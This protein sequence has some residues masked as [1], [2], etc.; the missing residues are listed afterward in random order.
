MK[1]TILLIVTFLML[2]LLSFASAESP[3]R[4]LKNGSS[5][6]DVKALKKRLYELGYFTS[7]KFTE[8]FTADTEKRIRQFES[9]CGFAETGIATQ[10]L[11]TLI[12]SENAYSRKLSAALNG[13]AVTLP[14]YTGN[15]Y[16]DF[17]D[18][19]SGDDVLATKKQLIIWRYFN[20]TAT[21]GTYNKTLITAAKSF[22]AYLGHEQTGYLT[23][24]EQELLFTLPTP[25]PTPSPTP[26]PTPTPKVTATP[27]GPQKQVELPELNEEHFLADE[28]AAPFSYS[29]RDD[30]QWYYISHD[31]SIAIRRYSTKSP[32]MT[33]FEAEIYCTP[34][35][36]P[37]AMLG[38]GRKADGYN[39]IGPFDI[40]NQYNALFAFSDDYFGIRHY[41][42]LPEGIII[43]G[44][45]VISTVTRPKGNKNFPPLDV[46]ALFND[47]TMRVYD[48]DE[49]TAEEYLQ[50]GVTDTFAFGP[51]LIE[52]SI[53]NES[54]FISNVLNNDKNPRMALGMV[55]PCHYWAVLVQGRISTSNGCT[56]RWLANHMLGMGCTQALNL[57]GGGS[58]FMWFMGDMINRAANVNPDKCRDLSSMFGYTYPTD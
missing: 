4:T 53:V 19:C 31:I 33:W 15:S 47:G 44:G 9:D 38:K 29:N 32:L 39:L 57:D 40:V 6:D 1:K 3:Y 46:L 10:E 11:Q 37:S 49:H 26:K 48:S 22:Q 56:F 7:N 30:G 52:D 16:R 45:E 54:L 41:N 8:D 28:S 42:K 18:G 51:I 5:G 20:S 35:S 23:A 13:E 14:E 25:S 55:E 2:L 27:K 43:R 24:E 50:M 58:T 36:L 21:T 12:Y 34:D 17:Y